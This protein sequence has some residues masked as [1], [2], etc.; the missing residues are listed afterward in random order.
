M[1]WSCTSYK[2]DTEVSQ[3]DSNVSV[4]D[5]GTQADE[6]GLLVLTAIE[7]VWSRALDG[8]VQGLSRPYGVPA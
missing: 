3:M 8:M 7:F 4:V 5:T 1:T 2:P 6:T